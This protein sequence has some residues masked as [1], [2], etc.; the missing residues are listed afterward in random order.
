M[1]GK[2]REWGNE[3]QRN[4]TQYLMNEWMKEF[5]T[6]RN[7]QENTEWRYVEW[8]TQKI[9]HIE[10]EREKKRERESEN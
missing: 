4:G 8:N 5:G 6:E 1:E 10:R 9:I 2:G 7:T 3:T